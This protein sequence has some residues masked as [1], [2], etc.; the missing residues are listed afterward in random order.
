MA[1]A[2]AAGSPANP[3]AARAS[4]RAFR[5]LKKKKWSRVVVAA[6]AVA[7]AGAKTVDYEANGAK[8][9]D[10]SLATE[11]F[12]GAILNASLAS[13]APGDVLVIPNKTF[14]LMGGVVGR[15]LRDVTI[16]VDGTLVF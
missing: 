2:S 7:V 3:D 14:H 10:D 9:D 15:H 5:L 12:N 1:T 4:K 6:C 11:V 13:L 16:S 8:P